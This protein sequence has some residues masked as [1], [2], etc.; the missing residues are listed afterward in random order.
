MIDHPRNLSD[1]LDNAWERH[2]DLRRDKAD[3]IAESRSMQL[4]PKD[5]RK[6]KRKTAAARKNRDSWGDIRI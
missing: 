5:P 4:T 2:C 3:E 1:L 6:A